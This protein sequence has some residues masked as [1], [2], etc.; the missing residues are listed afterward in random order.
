[1]FQENDIIES[2]ECEAPAIQVSSYVDLFAG[3]WNGLPCSFPPF[4]ISYSKKE[5]KICEKEIKKFFDSLSKESRTGD[6]NSN[7]RE[8]L[9][10]KYTDAIRAFMSRR[11]KFDN[12][13]LDLLFSNGFMKASGEFVDQAR[14]FDPSIT[15]S[16]LFQ[17][18]RNVWAMN[19]VQ[20]LLNLPVK[21]TPSVFAYSMLYPYTD[22]FLDDPGVAGAEKMEFNSRLF[23]RLSGEMMIP[24]P[25]RETNVYRLIGMIEEQYDRTQFPKVFESLICIYKA[26]VKSLSLARDKLPVTDNRLLKISL[27]K[28]G[29]SVLADGYLIAGNLTCNEEEFLFGYGAYLQL[30]D[31]LQDIEDDHKKGFTTLFSRIVPGKELHLLCNRTYHLGEWVLTLLPG[32]RDADAIIRVMRRM[33]QLMIIESAGLAVK[34][35]SSSF[36][37]QI[38]SFSPISYSFREKSESS[39]LQSGIA[40]VGDL[41]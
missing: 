13:D 2:A 24:R 37:G 41:L 14:K 17:A 26:Q 18:C 36:I 16:E 4:E 19:W 8:E 32:H 23:R 25:G 28:G 27:E 12:T 3:V 31:D 15:D 20:L 1:M 21:I 29:T 10:T 35:Y 6:S 39:F 38:E 34:Y 11:L 33:N 22:N 7:K 5:K 40:S 9:S 30:V